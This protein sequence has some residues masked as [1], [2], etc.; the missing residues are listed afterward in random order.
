VRDPEQNKENRMKTAL[1]DRGIIQLVPP[2]RGRLEVLDTQVPGLAHVVAP[3]TL[4]E[5]T[6][7]PKSTA[8]Q[9]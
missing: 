4:E 6:S 1:T 9:N 3:V 7:P 5:V 8:P 2:A